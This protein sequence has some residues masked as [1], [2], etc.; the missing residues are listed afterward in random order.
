VPAVCPAPISRCVNVLDRQR[1]HP[2]PVPIPLSIHRKSTHYHAAPAA[3]LHAHL[4]SIALCSQFSYR[5][6]R[7]VRPRHRHVANKDLHSF[8]SAQIVRMSCHH[9]TLF[10]LPLHEFEGFL[11]D[12]RI[13]LDDVRYRPGNTF[14]LRLT[15]VNPSSWLENSMSNC[16]LDDL[17]R[18]SCNRVVPLASTNL[19]AF[20]RTFYASAYSH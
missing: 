10:R 7:S 6:I 9:E 11:V 3:H 17:H 2:S 8:C 5:C 12:G 1:V 13:G 18:S 16:R 19:H 4:P 14:Y 15:F 20:V